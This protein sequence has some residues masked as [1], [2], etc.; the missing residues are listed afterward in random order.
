MYTHTC[1]YRVPYN[2]VDRLN[3]VHHGHYAK[4]FEIGRLETMRELGW[5][6]GEMED[7]G[8]GFFVVKMESKF[9]K[10]ARYDEVINIE[11]TIKEMPSRKIDFYTEITNKDGDTCCI[12]KVQLLFVNRKT[13]KVCSPPEDLNAILQPHFN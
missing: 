11:T 13:N 5:I 3:V 9:L 12:G 2:E 4:Y 6:Y 7:S 1:T 8:I 10:P